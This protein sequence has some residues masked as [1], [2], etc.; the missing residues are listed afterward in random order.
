M[1]VALLSGANSIHTI[2]WA[3][4]LSRKGI[5]IYVI[6]IHP[7]DSNQLSFD[8]EVKVHILDSKPPVGYF[9]GIKELKKLLKK[10]QPDLLNAHYATGYGTLATLSGF[11]PILLSLWGSDIFIFPKKSLIHKNI[12]RFN[13][14]NA[15]AIASTSNCM[16]LEAKKTLI[17]ERTFITPFGIDTNVFNIFEKNKLF[18]DSDEIVIG[19]VK[20]LSHIYGIDILLKSFATLKKRSI[21]KLKLLIFGDGPERENLERLSKYLQIDSDVSFMGS[22][23][24][25]EV[26]KVLNNIDI[27]VALSRSESFGVAVLEASSC[28]LPV[29]VSDADGLKEVVVDGVT[30]LIVPKENIEMTVNALVKLVED[31]SLRSQMGTNGRCHVVKNYSWEFSVNNMIDVYN[32]V[33]KDFA[34]I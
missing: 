9:L 16:A 24:H 8:K 11:H 21:T 10:I 26:P 33:I 34:K 5:D 32:N 19:T 3:N 1:R 18:I 30:G 28:A 22:I 15:D 20:T 23:D 17:S 29:V 31:S 6:S 4:G 25:S 7:I 2:R 27:F 12:L 13:M 14:R